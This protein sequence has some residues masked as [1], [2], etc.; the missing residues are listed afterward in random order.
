MAYMWASTFIPD[1]LPQSV[2]DKL[3]TAEFD[4]PLA[5]S[6]GAIHEYICIRNASTG[7]ILKKV[8]SPSARRCSSR[9][10]R[11][12]LCEGLAVQYS[13]TLTN[14][15]YPASGV[16]AHFGDGT[17][18]KGSIIIG[19]DGGQS[20]VR[21]L[22]LGELAE[23]TRLPMTMN[24]FNVQYCAEQALFIRK[25]LDRFTDYG[26]HPKGVFFLMAIQSVPDPADPST[27]S[28]QLLTSWPDS[29]RKLSEEENTS[30]G[31]LKVLKELTHNFSEP[32]KSAIEWVSDGTHI[33]RDRLAIW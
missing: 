28:F 16:V 20:K 31:R 18:A 4:Y 30:K 15:T 14:V 10:L 3:P 26:V 29:L 13:K 22:L 25:N 19:A 11:L 33:S 5:G 21:R 17:I 27:W 7:E 2:I 8:P 12:V 6:Q 1:L 23:P 9:R 24:N 32:R